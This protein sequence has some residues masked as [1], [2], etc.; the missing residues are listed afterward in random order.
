[1]WLTVQYIQHHSEEITVF[2]KDFNHFV[3]CWSDCKNSNSA[4]I[5]H[6]LI[7]S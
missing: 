2:I 4:Y 1:M 6:A 7:H 3:H 5:N